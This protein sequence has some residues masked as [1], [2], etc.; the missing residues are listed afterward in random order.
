MQELNGKH[1]IFG[2]CDPHSVSIVQ[3]I[4]RVEKNS[5]DKPI[6][7]VLI[8]KVTIVPEG[9]PMPPEPPPAPAA[10]APAP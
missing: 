4:A 3:A 8:N 5:Q 10:A 6:T 1:T 2:Q 7:P 9:A